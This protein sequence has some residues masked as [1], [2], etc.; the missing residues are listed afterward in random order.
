MITVEDVR[1]IALALP[2]AYDGG[3][4]SRDV[5]GRTAG[6]P[7][8]LA[9]R[10][11]AGIRLAPGGTSRSGGGRAQKFMLPRPSEMQYNWAV[12]RLDAIELD[13]LRELILDAWRMCVPKSVAAQI[14]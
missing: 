8:L 11:G 1:G 9:G 13:E 7:R 2:R 5:P 6:I 10:D 14:D 3:A 12:V 4:R